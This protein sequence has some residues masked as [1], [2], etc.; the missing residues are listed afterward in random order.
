MKIKKNFAH[1]IA[2]CYDCDFNEEWDAVEKLIPREKAY[3][4]AKKTWHR[5][6]VETWTFINYN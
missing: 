1:Q 3:N 4:H 6:T 5:V 2:Y